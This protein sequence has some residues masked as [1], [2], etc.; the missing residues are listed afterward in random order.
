[1]GAKTDY[2]EA[3]ALK[4]AFGSNRATD[5]PATWYVA[6]FTA[7]PTDAGGGTEVNGGGYARV[8]VP[9]DDAHWDLLHGAAD[10]NADGV[11]DDATV[12]NAAAIQYP[13]ATGDWGQVTH[14][15]LY[16]AATGGNLWIYAPLDQPVT[17]PAGATGI[18]FGP[19]A[20]SYQEDT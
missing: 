14:W 2:F 3:W 11:A 5:A 19:G 9:N 10:A 7:A 16:D 1:M 15:G 13:D 8:A 20:L 12:V 4:K 18:Q 17:I 6:L